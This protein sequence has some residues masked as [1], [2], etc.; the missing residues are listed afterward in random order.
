MCH[1]EGTLP[2]ARVLV[3]GSDPNPYDAKPT[4]PEELCIEVYIP[5]YLNAGL[6]QPVVT[7]PTT[8]WAYGGKH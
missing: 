3:S 1:S 5:P 4:F 2:D 8:D 7:I 6:T